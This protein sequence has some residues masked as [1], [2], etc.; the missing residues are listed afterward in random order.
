MRCFLD[1]RFRGRWLSFSIM[2]STYL[3][4]PF[5]ILFGYKKWG[6]KKTIYSVEPSVIKVEL[7][8]GYALFLLGL[9]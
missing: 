4:A 6:R 1:K 3:S 7:T 8:M 5:A 9:N 2:S